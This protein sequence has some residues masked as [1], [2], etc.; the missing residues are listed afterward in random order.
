[1]ADIII[2]IIIAVAALLGMKAGFVRAVFHLGYY[3]IAAIAAFTLYPFLSEALVASRIG[4][5]IHDKIIMPRISVDTTQIRTPYFIRHALSKGIEN[6]TEALAASLTEMALSI[7]CFLAVFLIVKFGLKLIVNILN[8][9]ARLPLLSF[10][11][12]AGGVAVG[13][14]NGIIV[15]YILLAIASIFISDRLYDMIEASTFAKMMYND[16]IL[17]KIIFG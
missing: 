14:F 1:M 5:Y 6:T 13:A 7:I 4:V 11:N 16:N 15:V 9:V 12:K 10:F 3:L 8:C 17:L 2:I